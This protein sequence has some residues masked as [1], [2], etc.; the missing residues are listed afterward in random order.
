MKAKA[1]FVVGAGIG[2]IFGTA[3]GR[4][5]FEKMKQKAND[6]WHSDSVQSTVDDLQTKATDFA[7]VQGGAL[8]DKVGEGVEKVSGT[9]KDKFSS[10]GHH[11][12]DA[13]APVPDSPY[14]DQNTP[15]ATHLR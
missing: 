14:G 9:V 10:E 3:A 6:M 11:T 7:K 13:P 15:G 4:Q 2:Y 12:A 1:A 5:K 8:A